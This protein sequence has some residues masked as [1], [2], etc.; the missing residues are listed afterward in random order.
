MG[1]LIA[2]ALALFLCSAVA[3]AQPARGVADPRAFLTAIYSHYRTAPET[4]APDPRQAYSRRL[5]ALFRAYDRDLGGGDLVG[6]LDFDWWV[7]AQDGRISRVRIAQAS[8]TRNRI[9]L[10]AR[11]L[12]EGRADSSRFIFVPAGR[13]WVLDEVINGTGHGDHGWTMSALLRERPR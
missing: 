6:S 12:N 8:R 5:A 11:W 9:V 10:T 1:R 7:N 13:R 2:W 4:P 3:E